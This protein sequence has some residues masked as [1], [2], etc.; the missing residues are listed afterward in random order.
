MRPTC[1]LRSRSRLHVSLALRGLALGAALIP[2][3]AMAAESKRPN[4]HF[5]LTDDQ[6]SATLGC[7]GGT[8]V[9][10]PHLER[11]ARKGVRFTDADVMPP[12]TKRFE[13]TKRKQPWNLCHDPR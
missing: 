3:V 5:I 7:Y 4:L 8:L 10:T 13:A 9:P 12:C 11:L 1:R 2:R 6:G